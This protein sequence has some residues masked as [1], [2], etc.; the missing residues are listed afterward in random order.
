MQNIKIPEIIAPINDLEDLH[1]VKK[2]KCRDVYVYHSI[3]LKKSGQD[4]LV[5]F[6]NLSK[7][8]EINF[9]INFKPEIKES[10]L[11]KITELFEFLVNLDFAG[12]LVNNY[13]IPEI[14]KNTGFS[15]KIIIDSGLNIHNL[16]STEFISSVC[17]AK[18]INITEEIYLKNLVRIKK[19]SDCKLAIDSNNLPWIA[20]DIL[21]SQIIDTIIIKAKF[22]TANDL[23][24]GIN[25]VEKIL[26]APDLYRNKKLPFK[27]IENSLYKTDHF[28]GEFQNSRGRTFKFSGSIYKLSWQYQGFFSK[29]YH[30]FQ[31]DKSYPSL[32]LRLT[33]LDQ[34]SE[35]K[36]YLKKMKNNPINSIEYGEILNTADLAKYSFNIII[37]TV[38][39]TCEDYGIKFK[40]GTPR[41]LTERDFDR[42][43]EYTKASMLMS[44]YP[45]SIVINNLGYWWSVVHDKSINIPIEIGSG[46]NIQNSLS[47]KLLSHYSSIQTVDFSNFYGIENIKQCIESLENTI[48]YR[49]IT[50]AGSSRVPSSGLCPL[51]KDSAILSRLSCTAPCHNGIYAVQDKMIKKS[52]HI[53]VDGFCRM[54]MFKDKILDLYKYIS[55]FREIGINEFMIDFSSLPSKFVP[56]LLNKYLSAINN[57]N[58]KTDPKFLNEEYGIEKYLLKNNL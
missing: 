15:H 54:H 32:N 26:E 11:K 29:N 5:E 19:Y 39:K 33:S 30:K 16:A 35:L 21:D 22:N 41:I 14:I 28:S 58:Y 56:V 27:N 50:I 6:I 17:N 57:P 12:I 10:E 2:T 20:K 55:L 23:I 36:K 4:K 7:E 53:A 45:K 18:I 3:F 25:S 38:K 48:L 46:L 1:F 13:S 31:L 49:Q 42:V 24:E 44:P 9:Y 8:L 43:Y 40:L 51:N 34:V 52:F 37:D 47:V